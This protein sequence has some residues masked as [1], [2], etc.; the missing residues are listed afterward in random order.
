MQ[1]LREFAFVA[2]QLEEFA[3]H[4]VGVVAMSRPVVEEAAKFGLGERLD[5]RVGANECEQAAQAD[6]GR[7]MEYL[8]A[9]R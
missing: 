7:A 2:A 5:S 6:V 3:K 1:V 9:H 8:I 4:V